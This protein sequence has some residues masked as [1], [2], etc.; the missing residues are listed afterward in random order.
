MAKSALFFSTAHGT[1]TCSRF[2]LQ[3]LRACAMESVQ[4][5]S[6][7][8]TAAAAMALTMVGLKVSLD[9]FL[10][11]TMLS[12]RAHLS[13]RRTVCG[14]IATMRLE[15]CRLADDHDGLRL[16]SIHRSGCSLNNGEAGLSRERNHEL[17]SRGSCN[18]SGSPCGAL[19]KAKKLQRQLEGTLMV[20]YLVI[21]RA[22]PVHLDE[23]VDVCVCARV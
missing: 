21:W 14:L 13:E 16:G 11:G 17:G 10:R 12:R 1:F 8:A 5:A 18:N 19:T 3:S 6:C 7:S 2:R 4:R 23:T 22:Q 15:C 20:R 9:E